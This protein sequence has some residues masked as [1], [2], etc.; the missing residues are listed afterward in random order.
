MK[1]Y[2][3]WQAEHHLLAPLSAGEEQAVFTSFPQLQTTLLRQF[4]GQMLFKI[5][6]IVKGIRLLLDRAELKETT[7]NMSIHS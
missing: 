7:L 1:E 5:N 4:W 6:I 3:Q 2:A